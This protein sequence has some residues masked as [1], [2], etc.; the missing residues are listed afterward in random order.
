M[1]NEMRQKSIQNYWNLQII[2]I[3]IDHNGLLSDFTSDHSSLPEKFSMPSVCLIFEY[4]WS[5][6]DWMFC[7]IWCFYCFQYVTFDFFEYI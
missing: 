4:F 3:N 5:T 1:Y 6:I 7:L 2:M